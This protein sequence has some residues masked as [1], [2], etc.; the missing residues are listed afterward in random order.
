MKP[1]CYFCGR[2]DINWK[3]AAILQRFTAVSKKIKS[4]ERTGLCAKHQRALAHAI[5]RARQ[6]A[7]LPFVSR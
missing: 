6:M 5:K 1:Q 2:D 4:R 7:L 3:D